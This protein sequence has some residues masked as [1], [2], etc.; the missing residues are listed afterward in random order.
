MVG[1][2]FCKLDRAAE[3]V[4]LGMLLDYSNG[5]VEKL[6]DG[7][8]L[9]DCLMLLKFIRQGGAIRRSPAARNVLMVGVGEYCSISKIEVAAFELELLQAYFA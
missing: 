1:N 5:G 6:E 8:L 7:N 4:L 9:F 2:D 3:S